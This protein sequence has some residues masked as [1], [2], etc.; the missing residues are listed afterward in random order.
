MT[1]LTGTMIDGK[2]HL[3]ES[4]QKALEAMKDI[5]VEAKKEREGYLRCG[6]QF[7]FKFNGGDSRWFR[8]EHCEE[9]KDVHLGVCP[10]TFEPEVVSALLAVKAERKT[11]IEWARR[12]AIDECITRIE[13]MEHDVSINDVVNDLREFRAKAQGQVARHW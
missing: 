5:E 12:D 3:D 1:K 9:H 8:I 11:E 10:K 13:R 4:S 7:S 2:L 6:C